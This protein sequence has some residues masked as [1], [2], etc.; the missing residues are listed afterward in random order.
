MS[1]FVETFTNQWFS[2]TFHWRD[3][4]LSTID[5]DAEIKAATPP[6]SPHGM[7]LA[8]IVTEYARLESDT[9]PDLPLD[10]SGYTPFSMHVL[11]TLRH[12]TP[13]GSCTTYGR[14]AAL[15]GTPR[16][17]RAVGGAMARNP[18]PL[19]YPC[20]RVLAGNMGL[21]GFSSGLALKRTLLTLE[22]VPLAG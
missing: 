17:A 16:A 14:L 2:A 9:W 4:L 12:H 20:H 11:E 21:G 1:S 6:K 22:K 19:L 13:R 10:R 8:R 18:W 7:E 15:C 3:G 5:L